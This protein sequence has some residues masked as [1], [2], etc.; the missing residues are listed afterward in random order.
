MS[1][2]QWLALIIIVITLAGVALGRFPKLRMNRATIVLVG[3]TLLII[4]RI[5]PIDKAYQV[6]D[7][8]TI[9]LLFSMM[10]I[11]ANLRLAGFF[12]LVAMQVMHWAKTPRQLLALVIFSSGIPS[13]L[14]LNDTICIMFTPLVIEVVVSLKCN[15][16]PYLSHGNY[17]R[18]QPHISG[19][20]CQYYRCRNCQ[21][22]RY[23]TDF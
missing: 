18:R 21:N 11:N 4:L 14:F 1:G 3:A 8:D 6:I 5:I 15:P 20:R 16:L 7:L 22:T 19:F 9:I 10:I 23:F 2:W 17:F 13:A 12:N